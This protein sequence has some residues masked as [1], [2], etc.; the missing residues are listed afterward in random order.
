MVSRMNLWAKQ[1]R[2]QLKEDFGNSCS[3]CNSKATLQFAHIQPTSLNGKGRG[4]KERIL[5]IR[6][7]RDSYR[8]LCSTC[9]SIYDAKVLSS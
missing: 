4:R 2:K 6:K 7:N 8:L 3:N 5:D 9:H 1:A